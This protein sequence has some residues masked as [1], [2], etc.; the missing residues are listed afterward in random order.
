ME[1][2]IEAAM[3]AD[4]NR[5][6]GG[7][8]ASRRFAY[9]VR[10]MALRE[11][12]AFRRQPVDVWRLHPGVPVTSDALGPQFVRH[13]KNQVRPRGRGLLGMRLDGCRRQSGSEKR[14][15][16]E[17]CRVHEDQLKW[18]SARRPQENNRARRSPA[19]IT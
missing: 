4:M 9:R 6:T 19:R 14:A 18:A 8:A 12:R 3:T 1:S 5:P 2:V 16:S 13:A 17:I 15:A 11:T 10:H 7:K